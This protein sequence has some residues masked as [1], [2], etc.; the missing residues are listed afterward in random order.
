MSKVTGRDKKT[1]DLGA[2]LS[3]RDKK[4]RND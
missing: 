3:M 2:E 4:R 1:R